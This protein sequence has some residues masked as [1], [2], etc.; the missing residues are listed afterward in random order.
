MCQA[1]IESSSTV[2]AGTDCWWAW[3]TDSSRHA[4]TFSWGRGWW[5]KEC[6]DQESVRCSVTGMHCLI[7]FILYLRVAKQTSCRLSQTTPP[8]YVSCERRWHLIMFVTVPHSWTS[9]GETKHRKTQSQTRMPMTHIDGVGLFL[10]ALFH[11]KPLGVDEISEIQIYLLDMAEQ[12]LE[13][14]FVIS[15]RAWKGQNKA[16]TSCKTWPIKLCCN[17]PSL[18]PGWHCFTR[19]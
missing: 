11:D 10:M 12:L 13:V 9:H 1:G 5:L 7:F 4:R 16:G 18:C 6:R 8:C 19:L 15:I 14:G 3:Q 2:A 17:F